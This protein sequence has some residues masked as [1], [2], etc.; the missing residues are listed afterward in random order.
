MLTDIA[1]DGMRGTSTTKTIYSFHYYNHTLIFCERMVGMLGAQSLFN[2]ESILS[3]LHQYVNVH[4][5]K[6]SS[7][8]VPT[9]QREVQQFLGLDNYYWCFINAFSIIANPLHHMTEKTAKFKWT[10]ECQTAFDTLKRKLTSTRPLAHPDYTQLRV[11]VQN[12]STEK[13]VAYAS[14]T[15]SKTEHQYGMNCWQ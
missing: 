9:C 6:V 11:L 7:W 8:P 4:S 13:V 2:T 5:N 10:E 12:E 1:H 3:Q 14:R 15:L